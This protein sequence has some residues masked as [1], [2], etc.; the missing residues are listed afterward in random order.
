MNL[1]LRPDEG[2][3]T[4][5][6]WYIDVLFP[7]GAVLLV[8]LARLRLVGHV[9]ARVTAELFRPGAEVIRAGAAVTTIEGGEDRLS[10]GPAAI[11][12]DRLAFNLP[13]FRGDL[14][15]SPRFGSISL[16][17]PF[18]ERGGRRL[19][20]LVE[21]PDADVTGALEWDGGR[22]DVVG[23]GYRDHVWFNLLPWR[24]PIHTLTWGRGVAGGHACTFV[25]ATLVDGEPIR[26]GW[27]D[28]VSSEL[29]PI[30]GSSRVLLDAAV[31]DLEGLRF[32]WLRPVLRALTGDPRE[33]K[34]AAPMG[35]GGED[36]VGVHE[37]VRW[38]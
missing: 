35:V 37:V 33:I 11:H 8:Y 21:V 24:F 31:V 19:E 9:V 30:I 34:Y 27:M 7:D 29:R 20:W 26:A 36:G 22:L 23:R 25:E 18:L 3:F 1:A 14:R 2:P 16:R 5:E 12:R 4:L 13:G 38:S 28:G 17:E 6:K 32:G 15:Y 10:F